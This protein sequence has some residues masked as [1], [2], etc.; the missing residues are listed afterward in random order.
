MTGFTGA[1]H[2]ETWISRG[3]CLGAEGRIW[4]CDWAGLC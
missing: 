2:P 4:T 3:S 1:S